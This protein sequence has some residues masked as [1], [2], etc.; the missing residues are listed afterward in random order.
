MRHTPE[1]WIR[2]AQTS[3]AIAGLFVGI[4]ALA[5]AWKAITQKEYAPPMFLSFVTALS[6]LELVFATQAAN[7]AI[8]EKAETNPPA[9]K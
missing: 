9:E 3:K 7:K 8:K 2:H 1:F 4:T 6:L 5:W